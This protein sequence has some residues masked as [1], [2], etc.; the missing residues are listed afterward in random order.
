MT[1]RR[2]RIGPGPVKN[3]DLRLSADIV[4]PAGPV[5][6]F[7]T[8]THGAVQAVLREAIERC[9][10]AR[11]EPMRGVRMYTMTV[12][13][14]AQVAQNH[15]IQGYE[16]HARGAAEAIA[17]AVHHMV[18]T[19]AIEAVSGR[20]LHLDKWREWLDFAE[21]EIRAANVP[22]RVINE[23]VP[24]GIVRALV[25]ARDSLADH[26]LRTLWQATMASRLPR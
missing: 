1:R 16:I 14:M 8:V 7:D 4:I 17:Q 20:I 2:R 21:A 25:Q 13:L 15:S 23:L 18:P 5:S 26:I 22:D 19:M 9:N 11:P 12:G 6:T 10:P 3:M 24:A